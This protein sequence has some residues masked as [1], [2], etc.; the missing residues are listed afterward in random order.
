MI[1]K[2][3][4]GENLVSDLTEALCHLCVPLRKLAPQIFVFDF[5]A[6]RSS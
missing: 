6:S 1:A 2:E 5:W 3:K 4:P